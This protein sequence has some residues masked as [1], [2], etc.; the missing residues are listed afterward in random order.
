MTDPARL[1]ASE[2]ADAIALGQVDR[3][4]YARALVGLAA[5]TVPVPL[6]AAAM[7]ARSLGRDAPACRVR[8]PCA[9]YL[10]SRAGSHRSRRLA[11]V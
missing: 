9:P 4:T 11:T 1:S 10:S 5:R 6:G 7:A 8:A 2:A 3:Q